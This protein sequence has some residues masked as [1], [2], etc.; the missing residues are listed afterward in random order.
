MLFRSEGV[1]SA[2]EALERM[3]QRRYA[4]VISDLD[5]EP[6]DGMALTRQIRTSPESADQFVPI[7]MLSGHTER[8]RVLAARDAGVTEFMTKPFSVQMLAQKVQTVIERPRQFVHTSTYFGPDRRRHS[9]NFADNER[10][11][12]TD[13]S[14]EVEVILG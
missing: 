13:K 12:L 11:I 6:M 14:P 9:E 10:R 2:P 7:I 3:R 4:L 5:M 1:T 8:A